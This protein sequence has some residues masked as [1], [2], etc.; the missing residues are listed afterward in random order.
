MCITYQPPLV[1]GDV[2]ACRRAACVLCALQNES[3][4]TETCKSDIN[5]Y[6]NVN[7]KDLTK[8][9]NSAFVGV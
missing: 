2:A 7:L 5:V 4:K 1:F 3:L 9:I 6:F 8:L